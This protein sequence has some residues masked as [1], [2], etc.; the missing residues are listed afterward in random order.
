MGMMSKAAAVNFCQAA[1]MFCFTRRSSEPQNIVS[2]KSNAGFP[3]Q[4]HDSGAEPRDHVFEWGKGIDE[5]DTALPILTPK[6][7]VYQSASEGGGGI[8]NA[9]S[10][11]CR[12]KG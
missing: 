11:A 4:M 6:M 5:K 8:L 7:I 10:G 9:R 2:G 1:T 12:W 3:A